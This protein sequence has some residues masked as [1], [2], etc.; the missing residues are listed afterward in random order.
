M[1]LQELINPIVCPRFLPVNAFKGSTKV[2][3]IHKALN[4]KVKMRTVPPAGNRTL[5]FPGKQLSPST[6]PHFCSQA[7][8]LTKGFQKSIPISYY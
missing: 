4:M 5:L 7:S 2:T 1:K 3:G 6:H 8:M